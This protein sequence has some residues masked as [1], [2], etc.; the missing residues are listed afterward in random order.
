M[1]NILL[2][3]SVFS[4]EPLVSAYLT[5]DIAYELAKENKVTV[6]CPN[7]T[8]PH[9]FVFEKYIDSRDYIVI[10]L[11]SF[12]CSESKL[13]GRFR[14]SYS[15]GKYCYKYINENN[16][17]I[18]VIY[19]NT[20]PLMAQYFTVRASRN[21]NIPIIIHVQDVYPES[22]SNKLPLLKL[23]IHPILMLVDKYVLKNATKVI[24]ISNE[25]KNHLVKSRKIEIEKIEVGQNWQNEEDFINFETSI[26]NSNSIVK[27]FTFMY[28]GNIGPVAGVN[29]LIEAF[30]FLDVLNCRL[31]IAGSGSMKAPLEKIVKINKIENI[32]FWSVPDGKVPE[33]QAKADV[34][35]LPIKKGAASSS[36][37]SKLPAYMFSKKPIIACVDKDSDSAK[38][39]ISANCGW[40][41]PPENANI[42]SETMKKIVILSK[43]DLNLVGE[44]GFNY[45]MEN[46]SKKKNL[47]KLIKCITDTD[48]I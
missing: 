14:E 7:P 15:F 18:D 36:I 13:F 34:L 28:L 19:A 48:I 30:T 46:L 33:I 11:N 8:R 27:P 1:S 44:N 37:P 38:V 20:W 21:N 12:T 6:L 29:L 22:L 17:N 2:I 31:V 25:M 9:S 10:R 39:I 47:E 4:P 45:A 43:N 32:E 35:L 5:K 41:L 16:K 26:D 42:L 24:A 40:V 3:S 23:L